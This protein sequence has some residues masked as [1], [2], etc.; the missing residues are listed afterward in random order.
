MESMSRPG[1]VSRGDRDLVL[2]SRP[3]MGLGRE[4][5][6]ATWPWCHNLARPTRSPS[7]HPTCGDQAPSAQLAP[8]TCAA[9]RGLRAL[10]AQRVH[11]VH[12]HYALGLVLGLGHFFGS[13]FMNII[14]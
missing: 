2:E 12:A 11:A 6:I 1:L 10:C 14:H 7:A 8:T 5:G 13:L 4:N 3:G 9:M